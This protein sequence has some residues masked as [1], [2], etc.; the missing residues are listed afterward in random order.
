LGL[1]SHQNSLLKR[2]NESEDEDESE[3]E[4]VKKKSKGVVTEAE[5]ASTRDSLR[6][7]IQNIKNRMVD[8]QSKAISIQSEEVDD[9][10]VY[11]Q[12]AK[13]EQ[14]QFDIQKCNSEIVKAQ[15]ELDECE[16]IL[17]AIGHKEDEYNN[18]VN[19]KASTPVK[20]EIVKLGAAGSKHTALIPKTGPNPV[21]TPENEEELDYDPFEDATTESTDQIYQIDDLKRRLG[22]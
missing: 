3:D 20:A 8:L 18:F 2:K 9:F 10:D 17:K 1:I 5:L 7:Y 19:L 15:K 12:E 22:Y 14:I 16:N 11:I 6:T 4:P 13:L 21:L